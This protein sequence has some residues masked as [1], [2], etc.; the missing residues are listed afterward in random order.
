MAKKWSGRR[1]TIARRYT[2]HRDHFTCW[3]C[4]HTGAN[5]LDH[6]HP[7][8]LF[9]HLTWE[10]TN[11]AAAHLTGAGTPKGCQVKGCGCIGNIA[12]KAT[13]PTQL[14]TRQW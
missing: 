10:P 6:I 4:G 9:P 11:W 5:S 8:S 7:K 14:P 2:L 3:L 13:P 1:V 12:R